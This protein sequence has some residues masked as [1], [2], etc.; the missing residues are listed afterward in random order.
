LEELRLGVEIFILLLRIFSSGFLVIAHF[1]RS[2]FP[3][4]EVA[5][6]HFPPEFYQL[7]CNFFLSAMRKKACQERIDFN[8]KEANLRP[9]IK[10]PAFNLKIIL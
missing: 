1:I 9:Y 4:T 7:S 5:H 10:F 6:F 3:S 2:N 8:G